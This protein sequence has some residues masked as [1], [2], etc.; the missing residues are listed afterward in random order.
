MEAVPPDAQELIA[1]LSLGGNTAPH[2]VA[3]ALSVLLPRLPPDS[4]ARA[5]CVCRAWR[6]AT[7][8]PALWHEL[9]FGGCAAR[10]HD[11]ALEAL[12][13]RAGAALLT[14]K[15]D[16][17]VCSRLTPAGVLAALRYGGCAG[18][19][20]LDTPHLR[21]FTFTVSQVQRLAAACPLLQRTACS[22]RCR[23]LD[24]ADAT[25]ALPGPLRL[26]AEPGRCQAQISAW[27]DSDSEADLT[28]LADC[29]RGNAALTELKLI[30][31][32]V[33]PV[34]VVQLV[35]SLRVNT[36]LY[37]LALMQSCI[38]DVGATQLAECLRFNTTLTTLDLCLN[39]ISFDGATQLA[40]SLRVNTALTTLDLNSNGISA[41]G[42]T[43][44]AECLRVNTA[45][46]SLN[47]N[48][49]G[50]SAEGAT[51]IGIANV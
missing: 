29:L 50:I 9:D 33:G 1:A 41:E 22:V 21:D 26:C 36:T 6:A 7:A 2:K 3:E 43:Q 37:S 11:Q 39:Q 18:L 40:E 34:G 14:L 25:A 5:A 45:L 48:S 46:T 17:A 44:L 38:G 19:R 27:S 32:K 47:L 28:Q 49:N 4:R 51:Q 30:G 23:L 10:V 13:V 24:V 35:H 12:C 20:R 31:A 16:A 15:L 8:H 42:A